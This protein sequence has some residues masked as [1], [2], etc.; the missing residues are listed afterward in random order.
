MGAKGAESVLGAGAGAG[1]GPPGVVFD[2]VAPLACVLNWVVSSCDRSL[3]VVVGVRG[4]LGGGTAAGVA[5]DAAGAAGSSCD[6]TS[7][8]WL[9]VWYSSVQLSYSL[10]SSCTPSWFSSQ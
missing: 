1:A 8:C 2:V 3:V 5:T 10:Y 7:F 4:R 6:D 9:C